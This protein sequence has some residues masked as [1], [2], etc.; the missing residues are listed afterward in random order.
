MLLELGLQEHTYTQSEGERTF[1]KCLRKL[2]VPATLCH[3]F[4][5]HE[6]SKHRRKEEAIALHDRCSANEE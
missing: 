6:N 3:G 5:H 1:R 2:P 4:G